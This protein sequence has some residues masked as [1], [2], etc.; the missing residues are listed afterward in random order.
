MKSQAIA[1]EAV[2]EQPE[3]SKVHPMKKS[4]MFISTKHVD[5]DKLTA[6]EAVSMTTVMVLAILVGYFATVN[7]Q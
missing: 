2:A 5:Y 7:W 1:T 3:V 4:Y 6:F